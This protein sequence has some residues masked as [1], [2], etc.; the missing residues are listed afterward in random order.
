M[1]P[2]DSDMAEF[3]L[4]LSA[5]GVCQE[6]GVTVPIAIGIYAAYS[7]S[8]VVFCSC[9]DAHSL[10]LSLL[11]WWNA[12]WNYWRAGADVGKVEVLLLL[13]PTFGFDLKE[14][15]PCLPGTIWSGQSMTEYIVLLPPFFSCLH[16]SCFV[17]CCFKL[18]LC[19]LDKSEAQMCP[20]SGTES[21]IK[22]G[23]L[24]TWANRISLCR[25]DL[26]SW[27][28]DLTE[29]RDFFHGPGVCFCGLL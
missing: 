12:L 15:N 18:V 29:N 27:L 26:K 17:V 14:Q 23:G 24:Q 21:V 8:V 25:A 11:I 7:S 2:L 6:P 4:Q 28:P 20:V 5:M 1:S 16:P 3:L 22:K 13:G 9:C 10:V 19:H